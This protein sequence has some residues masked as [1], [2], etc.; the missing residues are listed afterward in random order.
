[1][2]PPIHRRAPDAP[3]RVL[4]LAGDRA[5][6]R[7]RARGKFL[8]R[9]GEKRYVRG[10]TYGG[11]APNAAGEEFPEREAVAADFAAMAASGVTAVRTYTCP[12]AWLLDEARSHGLDV[13]V[14]IAW[15]THV[16]FLDDPRRAGA[17]ERRVRE[18][19]RSCAGHPAVLCFAVG[20]EIP[21]SIVRWHGPRRVER[22]IER[23]ARAVRAEDRDAL[24][25]Y[26]NF[27]ST[28]Y[29]ELPFLDLV[30]FNVFLEDEAALTHYLARLQSLSGDRPLILTEVG[31]D[32]RRNGLAAQAASLR[33]QVAASFRG[34]CAGVVVFSWTDEWHRGGV[35]VADWEFGLTTRERE[36]KPALAAVRDAFAEVPAGGGDE[37]LVSVVLCTHNGA[38]TLRD[39]CEGLARLAYPRHEVIVVDD[40]STDDSA[41]IAAAHGFRVISTPNQGLAAARNVGLEA[42]RGEIVAYLDDD[43]RPDPHWL[44]YLVRAFGEGPYVGV[45][46]PNLVPHDDGL[47]AQCVARAPGNPREV[48]IDDERAEHLP[49]CNMAFRRDALLAI[50]GFD[51][52]FR[53]AGD[54]VDVCWRLLDR[55][56]ALGFSPAAIVWHRR[57]AHQPITWSRPLP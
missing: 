41:A 54:D 23:L 31:L 10:V 56:E 40:G 42:A 34:G 49:G 28:E 17:I 22:F 20:N 35:D 32:S 19:V 1:M 43:A 27:P 45:G 53:I 38:L 15:E 3:E 5:G 30:C 29:L 57:R 46:G 50:G 18:A 33:W 13:I 26:V 14:G 12:P 11:F 8:E 47:V 6:G 37:P 55:G 48:L 39:C 2:P 7:P 16:A 52:Q 21:A 44:D 9:D 4:P 51:P 24:V 25:T 36:P